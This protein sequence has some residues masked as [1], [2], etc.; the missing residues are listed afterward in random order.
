MINID[1]TV[2]LNG[3][4]GD[5]SRTFYVGS[6]TPNAKRLVEANEEALQ[7][8]IQVRQAFGGGGGA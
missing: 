6:P 3:Y 7:E 1:V 2:Y 4:H 5:T 8:A